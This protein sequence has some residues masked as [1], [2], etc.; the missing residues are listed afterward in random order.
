MNDYASILSWLDKNATAYIKIADE[1]WEF[2]EIALQEVKSSEVQID[3]LRSE[4][5]SITEN[6]AGMKTAFSAEWG[7]GEPIIGFIGEYDALPGLSQKVSSRK[8][9]IVEGGPGH[10]CGHNLLGTGGMAAAVALRHWLEEN[11]IEGTV[12]YYGCPAEEQLWGKAFMARAGSFDDLDAAFNFHPATYNMP[13][14][15]TAVGIYD[16]RFKFTGI[17]AHAGGEP[18]RGR[19]ALDAVELMNVGVNYLREHVPEKVRMHYAIT[20]GGRVPNIVPETAEVWYYLRAPNMTILDDVFSRVCKVAEGAALMT[21]TNV[22]PRI[23]AGCSTVLNNHYLSD[24]HYDVMKEIGPICYTDV[25]KTFAAEINA[26]Y[27]GNTGAE[28]FADYPMPED[29]KERVEAV[30]KRSLVDDNFPGLDAL[31][32][33]TGSTDVGDVSLITPLTMLRTTC[34]PIGTA[35]HSWGA[36]AAAGMSIG[37]KG[38]M[39]AA[40]IMAC[41]ASLLYLRPEH[42]TKAREEFLARTEGSPYKCPVPP[43]VRIEDITSTG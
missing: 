8:E 1:I 21:G 3:H 42:L 43:E 38:M 33:R 15:G 23:T 28:L 20:D 17:T 39:H 27:P 12:R 4:G 30:R 22:E 7:K 41:A 37:H 2:A 5:F 19:S 13:G 6:I 40:K 31:D 36:T 29:E 10:G 18:H 11:E 16:V 14:K 9:A 26:A 35:S 24:L 25:E 32:V 34:F